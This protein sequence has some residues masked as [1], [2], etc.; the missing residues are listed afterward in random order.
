MSNSD[1]KSGFAELEALDGVII[2]L[3]RDFNLRLESL[4]ANP[5]DDITMRQ[6]QELK[7][8]KPYPVN[9]Y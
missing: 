4:Q 9:D 2:R 7:D 8:L 6:W 5:P 1:F 3:Q